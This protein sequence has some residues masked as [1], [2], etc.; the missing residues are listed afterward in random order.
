MSLGRFVC[1]ASAICVASLFAVVL[2]EALVLG[3]LHLPFLRQIY[4]ETP[5]SSSGRSWWP[6]RS[7]KCFVFLCESSLDQK[8]DH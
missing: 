1:V 7:L 4:V 8:I 3:L 6:Y 5:L 2:C